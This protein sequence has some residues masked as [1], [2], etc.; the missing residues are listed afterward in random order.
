MGVIRDRWLGLLAGIVGL[1][2][3]TLAALPCV[4]GNDMQRAADD[5]RTT[6]AAD[7]EELAQWCEADDLTDEARKTRHVLGPSDPNK[8]Y[9]P[10][11]SDEIGP[12]KL[13]AD[14]TEKVVEW[15]A[16]LQKLRTDQAKALY[17]IARRAV[18]AGR[19]ALAVDLAMAAIQAN[20]DH[21]PVRRLLGYQKFRD[22]WRTLYAAKKLRDGQVWSDKFGWLPKAHL[23]R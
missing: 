6:Y 16:R 14:A 17:E 11:L 13:P 7:V 9:L 23:R 10:V 5:L 8:L 20:P 3:A 12:P 22:Q 15:D 1:A 19:P 2:A 21:E 18:R 4:A